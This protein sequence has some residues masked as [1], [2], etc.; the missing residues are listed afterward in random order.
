RFY[1]NSGGLP[2]TLVESRIGMSYV[3]VGSTFTVTLS[4]AVSLAAGTYWVSVQA[5]QDFT[6]AGQW[7]WTDRTVQSNSAAAWQNPGGGFGVCTTWGQ[8]G[9]SCGIDVG[10]P[11]QVYR[12]NGTIGGGTPTPTPT[13]TA[14]PTP[15]CNPA[16]QNEP[17]M[18]ASRAYASAAVANNAF[19]VLTGYDASSPYVTETDYFNGT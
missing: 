5:R 13:P 17:N 18:L 16:W 2:G 7:G 4:P 1:T 6:P 10:V 14:T 15:T 12:L 9:G 3:Q 8:R 19:Y 11:D